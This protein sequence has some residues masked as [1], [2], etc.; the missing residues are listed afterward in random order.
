MKNRRL[1]FSSLLVVLALVAVACGDDD[2]V[3]TTTAAPA[4]TTTVAPTT[5]ATT[6]LPPEPEVQFDLG[7]TA[8]PCADAVN[9]GNGCI[10]LG[11]ITD[12]SGPFAALGRP[13]TDAQVDFWGVVNAAGGIDG[14]D[15]VITQENTIDGQYQGPATVEGAADLAARVLGLAQSLGTPQTQAAIDA[16]FD[17]QD[18]VVVP[19]TWWSGWAFDD[20]DRGLVMEAGSSYC[21]D[22]MNGLAFLTSP[23]ALDSTAFPWAVVYFQGDYGGDYLSGAKIAAAALGMSDPIEIAQAP[24]V[25]GGDAAAAATV[26]Q[27]V[28][29]EPMVVLFATGPTEMAKIAGGLAVAFGATPEKLPVLLG[30][31]PTWNVALKG[32][33]VM[34]YLTQAYFNTSPWAGWDTETPGHAAMRAAAEASD[35]DPANAYIAGWAFQYTWLTLLTEAIASGD[36]TRANVRA[37]AAD[38]EGIDFQG[39]VGDAPGSYA[40][41]PADFA[42]RGTIISK[43]SVDTSDGLNPITP[44]FTS[45]IA[46]GFPYEGACF[47]G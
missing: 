27:L 28:A 9:E 35:R 44:F 18:M 4:T 47:T 20:L 1:V 17:D 39:M 29:A 3:T 43:A 45:P 5:A 30:A 14:W 10:Y 26:A 7:V 13:L 23:N 34:P 41:E 32:S 21:F 22:A 33:A 25:V 37:L 15:V 40:G 42:A 12:L 8:A 16:V 36:L 46:A 2:A 31:G 11:I 19:A 38:L 6:T 24:D